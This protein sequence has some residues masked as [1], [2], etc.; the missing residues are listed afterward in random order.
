M[1]YPVVQKGK[2]GHYYLYEGTSVWDPV[3]KRSVQKRVY[4]GT[5]DE[6]G[7]LIQ[8]RASNDGVS[9]SPVFG[10]YHL[11]AEMSRGKLADSLAE[12]YGADVGG[13]LLALAILGCVSP[14]SLNQAQESMNDTYLRELLGVD[15]SFEQ[16]QCCRM[17]AEVGRDTV[18]MDVL[19]KALSPGKGCAL[20]DI[21]CLG[22]DSEME[23]AE[24]GRKTRLTQMKQVNLGMVH[25]QEDGLPFFFRTYPGSVA[26]VSTLRNV[27]K[28]LKE[29]GCN[30]TE[31]I[32]DRGFFSSGNIKMMLDEGMGFTIPVPSG[33]SVSK[34]LLSRSVKDIESSLSTD[35]LGGGVVRG[36]EWAV[37]LDEKGTFI[38]CDPGSEGSIRAVVL[39]DDDRRHDEVNTLYSRLK[40]VE[41]KLS[42]KEWT[43]GWRRKYLVK[44]DIRYASLIEVS[45]ADGVVSVKRKRNAIAARENA[46]GRF[47]LITTSELGWVDLFDHYRRRNDIEY[48]FSE[49][50]SDLFHGLK[51]KQVQES[52]D[53]GLIVSFL[54]VRLRGELMKRLKNSGLSQKMW[55]PDV[56]NVLKKLKIS[57]VGRVWRLNEVTKEQR[58]LL[59]SLEIPVPTTGQG[60]P[61]ASSLVI[62]VKHK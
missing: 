1:S 46:C 34:I 22:T 10:P 18:K 28:D 39:Q 52:A 2:N 21:V 43:D 17:L 4:K 49:L 13:R 37:T 54:S 45:E 19:F 62:N 27:V 20:F 38:L 44:A 23:Y 32:M 3:K 57:K 7:N 35:V 9:C 14:C 6:D 42:G 56:M 30:L 8:E 25:S 16:S 61:Q 59:K 48:D 53:G 11:Y 29:L 41:G 36:F 50:Q 58:E 55:V 40:E 12:V 24:A 47:V 26:D 33:R 15:W 31:L 51:G 60:P 5:C